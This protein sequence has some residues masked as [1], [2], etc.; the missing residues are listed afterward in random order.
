MLWIG[1]LVTAV[2]RWLYRHGGEEKD[3]TGKR[4][5]ALRVLTL[6][7]GLADAAYIIS[8]LY[9]LILFETHL[10]LQLLYIPLGVLL[11]LWL[12]AGMS[13]SFSKRFLLILLCCSVLTLAAIWICS[14]CL[15]AGGGAGDVILFSAR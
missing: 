14:V 11:E 6:L 3:S 4:R 15:G 8:R 1:N 7:M 13:Q 2:L 12:V 10:A 9:I 5:E